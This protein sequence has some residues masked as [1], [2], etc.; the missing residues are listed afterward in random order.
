MHV[1]PAH[2]DD[3]PAI[4]VIINREITT[5]AAHFGARRIS[6]ASLRAELD[7]DRAGVAFEPDDPH[8]CPRFIARYPWFVAV[9]AR[10]GAPPSHGTVVGIAKAGPWK[11]RESYART[12][13]IG[14][15][16]TPE[17]QGR[18][19]G[20][21]LYAALFPAL[22]AAGFHTILAGIA[23]PNPASVR[24]HESFGMHHAGTLPSV[25]HKLG[26]WR[27]VGYWVRVTGET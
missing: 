7:Q 26:S 23:L 1:R 25:G 22:Q 2:P 17:F 3:I 18:G 20:R 16:V 13:E 21:A 10:E 12:T 4:A 9:D 6:D 14:V 15:Y 8:L 27:D 11:P 24:L 19:I 5:G